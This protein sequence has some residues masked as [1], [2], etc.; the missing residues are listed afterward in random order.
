MLNS[1][2]SLGAFPCNSVH[3]INQVLNPTLPIDNNTSV[4]MQAL[5]RD[6]AT[7][8]TRQKHETRRD[9]ARLPWPPH[10][11]TKLIL[12]IMLHRRRDQRRPHRSRTNAV[13]T[14][15]EFKLLV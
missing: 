11:R 2:H 10:R 4:R 13:N 7:I 3:R 6:K 15:A 12:R 1:A 14:D 5:P 8:L 9:L